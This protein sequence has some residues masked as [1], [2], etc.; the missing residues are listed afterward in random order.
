MSNFQLPCDCGKSV[1]VSVRQAGQ[2][3][4]CSCGAQLEVPT[5]RGLQKLPPADATSA[6][7]L[8]ATWENRQRVIF[9]LVL[10]SLCALALGAYLWANVPSLPRPATPEEI[11]RIF[12]AGKPDQVYDAFQSLQ[13]GLGT[14]A[15]VT[16]Q[17]LRDFMAVGI[18]VALGIGICGLIAA[19]AMTLAGRK[20]AS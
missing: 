8:R 5:L 12:A 17:G 15:D 4:R 9:S 16:A 10:I 1:S 20:R 14:P 7:R 18:E 19:V 3:V 2:T 13:Q 6:A 11:K